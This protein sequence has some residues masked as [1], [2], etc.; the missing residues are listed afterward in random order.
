MSTVCY[1]I[2]GGPSVQIDETTGQ[3]EAQ[4]PGAQS[5]QTT[6]IPLVAGDVLIAAAAL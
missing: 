6:Q 5:I 1:Q 3:I 4:I 2:P